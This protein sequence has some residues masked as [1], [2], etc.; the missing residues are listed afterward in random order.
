MGNMTITLPD[1]MQEALRQASK[2]E[3]RVIASIIRR[4][5]AEYLLQHHDVEVEHTMTWGGKRRGAED[6]EE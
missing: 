3:D 4:A 1:E 6:K 2:K 5:I